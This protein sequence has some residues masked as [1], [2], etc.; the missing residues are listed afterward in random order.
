MKWNRT[1]VFD[2]ALVQTCL[3]IITSDKQIEKGLEVWSKHK[4]K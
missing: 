1:A 3:R 4:Y 2:T